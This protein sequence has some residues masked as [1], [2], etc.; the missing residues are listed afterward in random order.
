[1]NNKRALKVSG[2][3]FPCHKFICDKSYCPMQNKIKL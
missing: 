1:V 2:Y 3:L